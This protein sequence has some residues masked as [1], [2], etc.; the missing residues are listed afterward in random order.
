MN[1]TYQAFTLIELLVVIAIIAILAAILFPV[2]AQAKARALLTACASNTR[3]LGVAVILYAQD[4][5]DTLV[6]VSTASQTA[7]SSDDNPS[8]W[9]RLVRPY[10]ESRQIQRCPADSNAVRNSYGLNE[11]LF[12][13]LSDPTA[14][15]A[16]VRSATSVDMPSEKVMLGELGTQDDFITDRP[17][18]YKLVAPGVALNDT[19]DARP[20]ARHFSRVNVAFMDGHQRP[21][22]L[23]QF[24]WSQ[25]PINRWFSP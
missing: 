5:D 1:R 9:T 18:A 19:A 13:D 25:E 3:Q 16:P 20:S 7:D 24:Y 8:L 14:V 21:M 11:L 2:F 10:T 22:R 15:Q 4:Y 23:E 17:D 6:P 12:A